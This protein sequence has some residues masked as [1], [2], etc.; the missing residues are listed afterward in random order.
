MDA[1]PSYAGEARHHGEMA[2]HARGRA[3]TFR[4]YLVW[5]SDP[6]RRRWAEGM[7]AASELEAI[8]EAQF[9]DA[10]REQVPA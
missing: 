4:S 6:A 7:A 1:T 8:A 9:A 3:E 5:C 2:A 10:L